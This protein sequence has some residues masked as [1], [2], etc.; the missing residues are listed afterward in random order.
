MWWTVSRPH[1]V[2]M[3][4]PGRFQCTL[5]VSVK[6][7]TLATKRTGRELTRDDTTHAEAEIVVPVV[8]LVPVAVRG[9]Q[10]VWGVVPGPT[11]DDTGLARFRRLAACEN[12]ARHRTTVVYIDSTPTGGSAPLPPAE[13]HR[14]VRRSTQEVKL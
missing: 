6:A 9:T 12:P 10:V 8:E 3:A 4:N 1:P 11:A 5:P 7:G 13:I 2:I 14:S